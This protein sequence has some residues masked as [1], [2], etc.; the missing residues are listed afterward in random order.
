MIVKKWQKEPIRVTNLES[1]G[2]VEL[3]GYNGEIDSMFRNGSLT[4]DM[5]TLSLNE[6]PSNHAWVFKVKNIGK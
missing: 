1:A 4:I 2:V 6:L 3:L 5:P